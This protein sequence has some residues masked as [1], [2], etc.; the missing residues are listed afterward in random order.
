M[1]TSA[2][3]P[4]RIFRLTAAQLAAPAGELQ[5]FTFVG[6]LDLPRYV[7]LAAT[8]FVRNIYSNQIATAFDISADGSR[9]LVLTYG[10][11]F[12]W[13]QDLAQPFQSGRVLEPGRDFTLTDLPPLPQAESVA[14]L[15]DGDGIVY[16]S[17]APAGLVPAPLYRQLC[18][19]R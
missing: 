3:A 13:N 12:E 7:A 9:A 11:V 6:S 4:A 16:S 19:R 8:R 18:G 5:T 1:A 10:E 14:Y 2:A 15:P 17:E